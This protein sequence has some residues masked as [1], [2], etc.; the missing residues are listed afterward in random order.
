[1]FS[2]S[3][4]QAHPRRLPE[5]IAKYSQKNPIMI[6]CMTRKSATNTAKLLSNWWSTKTARDRQ[7]AGPTFR[8]VAQDPDLKGIVNSTVTIKM[9]IRIQKP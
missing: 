8:L 3:G 2:L 1:M 9:L 7:W 4:Y 6:F 5:I